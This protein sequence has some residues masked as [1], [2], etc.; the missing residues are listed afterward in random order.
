MKFRILLAILAI[1]LLFS[2]CSVNMPST[3]TN[4]TPITDAPT[5]VA[6]TDD[7][8]AAFQS[9]LQD[10]CDGLGLFGGKDDIS[11]YLMVSDAVYTDI[12]SDRIKI[13]GWLRFA[14]YTYDKKSKTI[15]ANGGGLEPCAV[16]FDYND[17]AIGDAREVYRLEEGEYKD[18][19]QKLS[20]DIDGNTIDNV[21][22]LFLSGKTDVDTLL[23]KA[24][25][26]YI[27]E[28]YGNYS[29]NN[30]NGFQVYIINN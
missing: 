15:A 2:A 24:I 11:F 30:S 5:K 29:V 16:L 28:E 10:Y 4:E 17:K 12:S 3:E 22:D 9:A 14:D 19:L 27:T 13:Y 20:A 8:K 26:S 7:V 1:I 21:Y 25:Q 18:G 23:D 6:V